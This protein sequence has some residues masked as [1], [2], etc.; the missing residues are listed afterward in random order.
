MSVI[1][2]SL[3]LIMQRFP[4]QKD[5]L[6]RRYL[7]SSSF[8]TLC[9][10]YR[11]CTQALEHWTRSEHALAPERSR[12]YQELLQGLENE[13]AELIGALANSSE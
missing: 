7:K 9:D 11:K 8:Q 2:P 1:H 12:D 3:F 4:A 10:D 6:R 13:I 5:L